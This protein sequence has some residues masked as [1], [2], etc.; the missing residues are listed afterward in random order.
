MGSGVLVINYEART[1]HIER[2]GDK[3]GDKGVRWEMI[4]VGE[5]VISVINERWW[6]YYFA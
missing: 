5:M 6:K 3:N 2:E 1:L 4:R